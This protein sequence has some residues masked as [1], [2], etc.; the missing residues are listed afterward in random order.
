MN[1]QKEVYGLHIPTTPWLSI[2]GLPMGYSMA[3]FISC[4]NLI[5]RKTAISF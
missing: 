4:T 5:S 1:S 3:F 2:Q